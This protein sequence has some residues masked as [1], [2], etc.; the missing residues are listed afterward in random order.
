MRLLK[1]EIQINNL[2]L[3]MPNFFILD[4]FNGLID[5]SGNYEKQRL[6]GKQFE[7][8]VKKTIDGGY[9]LATAKGLPGFHFDGRIYR[10]SIFSFHTLPRAQEY[11]ALCATGVSAEVSNAFAH[12]FSTDW[13]VTQ[14]NPTVRGFKWSC[15]NTIS[16]QEF[17]SIAAGK[18]SLKP[19]VAPTATL[20]QG[21]DNISPVAD[22][23]AS[24]S[25]EEGN[26][27]FNFTVGDRAAPGENAIVIN[28]KVFIG[29]LTIDNIATTSEPFAASASSMLTSTT[30]STE[31]AKPLATAVTVKKQR[32]RT[33]RESSDEE[34]V[35]PSATVMRKRVPCES[36]D[37]S[38]SE[39][40]EEFGV[41][42]GVATLS[43]K[44][45]KGSRRH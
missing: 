35:K 44:G 17:T 29:T 23:A 42:W 24:F 30:S 1:I 36:S 32:K 37:S 34:S 43:T 6:V 9:D 12:G 2:N 27:R 38:D 33:L 7:A 4:C 8:I 28:Q 3:P 10:N 11:R 14:G 39:S 19:A 15:K 41:G 31:Y 21:E 5:A 13:E 25:F 45:W 16:G 40:G 20:T 18:N 26:L 22:S